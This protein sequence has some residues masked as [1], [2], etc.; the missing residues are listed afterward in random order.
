MFKYLFLCFN[1]LAPV[2]ISTMRSFKTLHS[3]NSQI[4]CM[5]PPAG[6][7]PSKMVN[8]AATPSQGCRTSSQT[9]HNRDGSTTET[10]TVTCTKKVKRDKD[11]NVI[12]ETD[13]SQPRYESGK[14]TFF[15]PAPK[16][17]SGSSSSKKK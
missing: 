8:S 14:N 3:Y 12:K 4:V 9:T 6:D 13:T 5:V 2:K 11:G 7:I 10:V 17:A 15:N 1:L 16:G